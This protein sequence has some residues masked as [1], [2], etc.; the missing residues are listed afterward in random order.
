[1]RL[2]FRAAAPWP[3]LPPSTSQHMPPP[4]AGQCSHSFPTNILTLIHQLNCP[5]I[6][7][8]HV[9]CHP[10]LNATSI[11]A[12][13]QHIS[14]C[15]P[16]STSVFNSFHIYAEKHP[17]PNIISTTLYMYIRCV[18]TQLACEFLENRAMSYTGFFYSLQQW[19]STRV[20]FVLRYHLVISGDIFDYTTGELR[21]SLHLEGRDQRCC[22]TTYNAQ[23]S[24]PSLVTKNYLVQNIHCTKVEKL[25]LNSIQDNGKIRFIQI[26]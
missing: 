13:L 15:Q 24:L 19:F 18:Y 10:A 21:C 5:P 17:I 12:P 16:I 14:S 26:S 9:K 2:C 7:P 11:L 3:S 20:D 4:R 25:L 23:D 6:S 1:M 8:T 22:K